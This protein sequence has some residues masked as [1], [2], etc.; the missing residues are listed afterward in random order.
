VP[1]RSSHVTIVVVHV[2]GGFHSTFSR[3]LLPARVFLSTNCVPASTAGGLQSTPTYYNLRQGSPNSR[4][5]V[6]E[7]QAL[8]T[9]Q[10]AQSLLQELYYTGSADQHKKVMTVGITNANIY[11]H[12]MCQIRSSSIPSSQ[13]GEVLFL[14]AEIHYDFPTWTWTQTTHKKKKQHNLD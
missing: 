3:I 4:R 9:Y 5:E 7:S 10:L 13:S 12:L 6:D 11:R 1:R 14:F 8:R 2:S